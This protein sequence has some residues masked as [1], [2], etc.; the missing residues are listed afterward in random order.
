MKLLIA[1]NV[2]TSRARRRFDHKAEFGVVPL[3][4][5]NHI[6]RHGH[7]LHILD[8]PLALNP[9]RFSH[10]VIFVLLHLLLIL[11]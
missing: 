1:N 9:L 3:A 4:K 10:L 11:I 7:A 5:S 6:C 2:D 8:L